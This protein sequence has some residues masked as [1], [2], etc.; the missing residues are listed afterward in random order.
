MLF[1]YFFVFLDILTFNMKTIKLESKF[2]WDD[3][4]G[5]IFLWNLM[6]YLLSEKG[7]YVLCASVFFVTTEALL[8][9]IGILLLALYSKIVLNHQKTC[10]NTKSCRV[11][12]VFLAP[13]TKA[14][15]L[16]F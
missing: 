6:S 13:L 4:L 9:L 7:L 10:E 2:Y 8:R 12:G 11:F 3:N 14:E 1:Y 15:N 5:R 16:Y